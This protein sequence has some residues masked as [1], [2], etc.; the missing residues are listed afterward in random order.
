[1]K[2]QWTFPV[3]PSWGR[4]IYPSDPEPRAPVQGSGRRRAPSH[5]VVRVIAAAA[6]LLLLPAG[7]AVGQDPGGTHVVKKGDTLWDLA[8]RYLADPFDWRRIHQLNTA[9]VRNPH[10]IFP[11]QELRLPGAREAEPARAE[12]RAPPAEAQP[13]AEAEREENLSPREREEAFDA[14]S[15]FDRTP[16][17]G[18]TVSRLEVEEAEETPVVTRSDFYRVSFLARGFERGAK[19]VTAR[20]IQEN[21]LNLEIPSSAR[22]RN[23]VVLALKGL[24][25]SEGDVLQAVRPDRRLKG[26]GSVMLSMAILEVRK[27]RGDSAHAVVQSIYGSYGVGDPAVPAPRYPAHVGSRYRPASKSISGRILGFERAQTLVSTGDVIF[28]SVGKRD[29]VRM[30]DEFAVYSSR[31]ESLRNAEP[32]DRIAVVRAVRV[33][34]GNTTGRVVDSSDVGIAPGAL[35]R[36][37]RR[38]VRPGA[39]GTR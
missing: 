37:V 18:V 28:L 14:P 35:V 25:V 6:V 29:G 10:L 22:P 21:P 27:V 24:R 11:G 23:R 3:T 32:E 1:M 2:S 17:T 30:G 19:A 5:G 39:S 4:T 16:G 38:P 13:P 15:V 26:H 8:D 9:E 36:L 34:V 33:R 7:M 31:V 20:V 12:E